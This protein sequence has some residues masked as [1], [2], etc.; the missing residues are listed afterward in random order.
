MKTIASKNIP[1]LLLIQP[2]I[3]YD[4]RGEYVETFN[5]KNYQFVGNDGVAIHFKEDDI[6]V[7]SY[8]VLRGLHGDGKTW[9]LIQCLVGQIFFVVVDMRPGSKGYLKYESFTLNEKNR[10]QVLVPANCANGH[11]CM[12]DRCVFSYKQSEI[13]TGSDTQFTLRWDDPKLNIKWPIKSPLLSDRDSSAP[14]L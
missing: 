10:W 2:E 6:S 9:K 8:T 1:D 13:Y 7:S 5:S 3:F 12:S 4:F 11:L 14:F